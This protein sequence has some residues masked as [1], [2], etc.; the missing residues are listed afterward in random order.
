MIVIYNKIIPFPGYSTIN[1]FGILFTRSS[2]KPLPQQT[3]THETIH[4]KQQIE[5]LFVGFYIL[6]L[7]FWIF[8]LFK[9]KKSH[10]AYYMIPFEQEA[11]NHQN[12]PNYPKNR[13]LYSWI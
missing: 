8:N 12:D 6:Y 10:L 1:L 13:K 5:L 2:K 11:Y 7:I 3:I 4:T 9:Y